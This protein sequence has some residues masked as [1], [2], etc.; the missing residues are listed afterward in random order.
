MLRELR[1]NKKNKII[2]FCAKF[3]SLNMRINVTLIFASYATYA[4]AQDAEL[5]SDSP[6]GGECTCVA[7][8]P[9]VI[10]PEC[11]LQVQKKSSVSVRRM[12]AGDSNQDCPSCPDSQA[13]ATRRVIVNAIPVFK[14]APGAAYQA[15]A[16]TAYTS[17][18][19]RAKKLSAFKG[20]KNV[21][22]KDDAPVEKKGEEVD[23]ATT[24]G[25][26][27]SLKSEAPSADVNAE[28][29]GP[30]VSVVINRTLKG[31][32]TASAHD[33]NL[34]STDNA[35]LAQNSRVI[36]PYGRYN[37][38]R[39][40]WGSRRYGEPSN[41]SLVKIVSQPVRHDTIY[42]NVEVPIVPR[43]GFRDRHYLRKMARKAA[44]ECVNG[45]TC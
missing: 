14:P 40:F 45:G 11:E 1:D 2:F 23:A 44:R 7:D 4:T 34:Q 6:N 43:L 3:N 5:K 36:A 21:E 31:P 41:A 42:H 35:T 39:L 26:A 16:T 17:L 30:A 33:S 15:T 10:P 24:E 38:R 25:D 32:E 22:A 20:D 9:C 8:V 37:V 19:K 18:Y 29:A 12:K 13:V 27:E 28:S